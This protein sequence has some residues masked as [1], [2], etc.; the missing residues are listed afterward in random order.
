MSSTP[1]HDW[2]KP[3]LDAL[4]EEGAASGMQRD[5]IVAVLT[6]IIEGPGY[7]RAVVTEADA[8]QPDG[9]TD[10]RQEPLSDSVLPVTR[11][12]W[13]PYSVNTMPDP[14]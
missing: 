9:L 13:Y 12:E 8:P 4:V 2:V 11:G 5:V 14:K 3:R 6:D 1:V 7:N 10:P